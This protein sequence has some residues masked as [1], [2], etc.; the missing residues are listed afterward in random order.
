MTNDNYHDI[1]TVTYSIEFNS[2]SHENILVAT[3]VSRPDSQYKQRIEF[4][5]G[6]IIVFYNPITYFYIQDINYRN[7][8]QKK[9]QIYILK[10]IIFDETNNIWKKD[11][12]TIE[13]FNEE[14]ASKNQ[15]LLLN[16]DLSKLIPSLSTYMKSST[17]TISNLPIKLHRTRRTNVNT[18]IDHKKN[19]I[20]ILSPYISIEKPPTRLPDQ[21]E[22]PSNHEYAQTVQMISDLQPV[23]KQ[24]TTKEE[25]NAIQLQLNELNSQSPDLAEII[26]KIKADHDKFAKLSN[27]IDKITSVGCISIQL[28]N[29]DVI[30]IE[31][32]ERKNIDGDGKGITVIT[33]IGKI[34][35]MNTSIEYVITINNNDLNDITMETLQKENST[36]TVVKTEPITLITDS[37]NCNQ[38]PVEIGDESNLNFY[39]SPTKSDLL[40]S[41]D[42]F[43]ATME[44]LEPHLRKHTTAEEQR[45][46]Y[47]IFVNLSTSLMS[48][49]KKCE[50]EE[51]VVI[52]E[53][54]INEYEILREKFRKFSDIYF[55]FSEL[56]NLLSELSEED[57]IYIKRLDQ[58]HQEQEQEQRLSV[59]DIQDTGLIMIIY[60]E[61]IDKKLYKIYVNKDNIFE[62]G[63]YI[64]SDDSD[65]LQDN[66]PI[67]IIIKDLN[68]PENISETTFDPNS[69]TT[70]DPNSG[71]TFDRTSET[72][73]DPRREEFDSQYASH[74]FAG[75][76]PAT[77]GLPS[78]LEH[79]E[80]NPGYNG[81]NPIQRSDLP[82]DSNE[83]SKEES[84]KESKDQ[85]SS[86][87]R[88]WFGRNQTATAKPPPKANATRKNRKFLSF[89]GNDRGDTVDTVNPVISGPLSIEHNQLTPQQKSSKF[90]RDFEG[91]IGTIS[92][93]LNSHKYG[94]TFNAI[95]NGITIYN[96]NKFFILEE[97][98]VKFQ[99]L[100][101]TFNELV[102]KFRNIPYITDQITDLPT[103]IVDNHLAIDIIDAKILTINNNIV[104]KQNISEIPRQIDELQRLL[105]DHPILRDSKFIGIIDDLKSNLQLNVSPNLYNTCSDDDTLHRLHLEINKKLIELKSKPREEIHE[106]ILD[107]ESKLE[108]FHRMLTNEQCS[109][110]YNHRYQQ[111]MR[112]FNDYIDM[113]ARAQRNSGGKRTV[114][115]HKKRR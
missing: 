20:E 76:N 38:L 93:L 94:E 4:E 42:E 13:L 63:L 75:D 68:C 37:V 29:Q 110:I 36:K 33:S 21:S 88:R 47:A 57:C 105:E 112:N 99:T 18:E 26:Q 53:E 41:K 35:E 97:D 65:K 100:K 9:Q 59:T 81:I 3:P 66:I 24:Y 22:N 19:H 72:T 1:V 60:A 50:E 83:E 64:P 55:K 49:R 25:Q 2:F 32:F 69:E 23:V 39:K 74:G 114:R 89:F 71:T 86:I 78:E 84:K 113:N 103:Q 58:E 11:Q 30:Q 52:K 51:D 85:K 104:N 92:E 107:I 5:I 12:I 82:F 98:Q 28:E 67:E 95:Q 34:I 96:N 73:I 109:E 79:A 90:L 43:L 91:K 10:G 61:D 102:E 56:D 44:R 8:D 54:L 62:V 101:T 6:Y 106:A 111:L 108:D 16:F 17:W 15:T 77:F 14:P 115:K 7:D 27:F 87:F 70:F 40:M 45:R 46:N 48:Y 80:D 31:I